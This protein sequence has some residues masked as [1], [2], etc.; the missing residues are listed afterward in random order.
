MRPDRVSYCPQ[1]KREDV[2]HKY[3]ESDRHPEGGYYST[4]CRDCYSGRRHRNKKWSRDTT[5]RR[6]RIKRGLW[7][8]TLRPPKT[9]DQCMRMYHDHSHTWFAV[10]Y[11]FAWIAALAVA[12]ALAA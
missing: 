2:P 12:G 3:I 10:L 4:L 9:E 11:I 1:C 6:R 7:V 5:R 8:P